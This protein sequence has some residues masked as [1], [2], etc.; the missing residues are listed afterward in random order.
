MNKILS[1][2][3]NTIGA[4]QKIKNK[5]KKKIIKQKTNETMDNLYYD[6]VTESN[7]K[8]ISPNADLTVVSMKRFILYYVSSVDER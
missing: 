3:K 7:K 4:K 2:R 5:T 6:F 1:L 8:I